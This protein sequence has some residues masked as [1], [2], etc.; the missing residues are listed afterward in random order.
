MSMG[1]SQHEIDHQW[2][3]NKKH[4]LVHYK[5]YCQKNKMNLP[6]HL[7]FSQKLSLFILRRNEETWVSLQQINFFYNNVQTHLVKSKN[8]V[9]PRL[10]AT[11]WVGVITMFPTISKRYLGSHFFCLYE[12]HIWCLHVNSPSLSLWT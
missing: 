2:H 3:G 8:S 1:K 6:I 7:P 9:V 12:T 4:H 11:S 10:L 5:L